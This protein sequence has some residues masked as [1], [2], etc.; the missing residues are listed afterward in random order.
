[1]K[2]EFISVGKNMEKFDSYDKVTG[3]ATYVADMH[4][5]GMLHGKILHSTHAHALIKSIDVSKARA[6]P[7]V[8]AVLT[9]AD[10][11]QI[12]YSGCGHPMPYDTPLDMRI[13]P[14]MLATPLVLSLQ[15]RMIS[16]KR[17][18]A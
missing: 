10:V 1:M 5:P 15:R 14:A 11:P 3:K 8:H 9:A 12:P 18:C 2:K 13:I 6:L 7:G 4:L 16:Q 17:L